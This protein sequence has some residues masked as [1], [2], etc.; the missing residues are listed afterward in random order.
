MSAKFFHLAKNWVN[1]FGRTNCLG[2]WIYTTVEFHNRHHS[3]LSFKSSQ[4]WYIHANTITSYVQ[5]LSQDQRFLSFS[6]KYPIFLKFVIVVSIQWKYNNH[7]VHHHH[8]HHHC[9]KSHSYCHIHF[10][11]YSSSSFSLS[12]F[13]VERADKISS[14]FCKSLTLI[15]RER[16]EIIVAIT[17]IIIII[18]NCHPCSQK[19]DD[20]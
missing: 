7:R 18:A 5:F 17:L 16:G 3:S 4:V 6:P 11:W 9:L 20:C 19:N 13:L 10:S 8:H 15:V 14:H 1:V 2:L 12:G